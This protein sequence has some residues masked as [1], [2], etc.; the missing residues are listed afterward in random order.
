[1]I[2]FL[3]SGA[4]GLIY[5]VVWSRQLTLFVGITT[6]AHTA[7]ITAYMLGLALGSFVIG[8]LSDRHASPLRLFAWLEVAI[9]VYVACTP[10]LLSGFQNMYADLAGVVG[11]T[12]LPSHLLRFLFAVLLLLPPTFLM[13]GT[14]PVMIRGMTGALPELAQT[15]GRMYGINTLG[16]MLGTVAAG[17]LLLP[18]LGLR[19][20]LFTGVALDL[21]V[22]VIIFAMFPKPSPGLEVVGTPAGRAGELDARPSRGVF[23][24]FVFLFGLSGFAAL[25]Y[26]IAWIRA[27]TLVL[28]SSVYSFSATL[29]AFLTGIGLG[30]LI[31][32]RLPGGGNNEGRHLQA[33]V[34]TGLTGFCAMSGLW[35]IGRLPQIFLWGYQQGWNQHFA[36][37]QLFTFALCMLVMLAPTFLLGTMFPLMTTLWTR[38]CESVGRDVG[39]IY[40]A[41]TVGCIAGAM[42]GGLFLLPVLGVHGSVLLAAGVHLL[43]SFGFAWKIPELPSRNKR[44]VAGG[45]IVLY[46]CTVV[47]L[48]AWD[49]SIMTSGVFNYAS[50]MQGETTRDA[51]NKRARSFNMLYYKDG[52]DSTVNVSERD[53]ERFL[54]IN[55]KI[56]AST[57]ADLPTQFMLGQLAILAHPNPRNV[58]IVGLG[59]GITAGAIS[60]HDSVEHIDIV[61]ISP[62]VVEASAYFSEHNRRILED[63]RVNLVVADARNYLLASDRTYDVI[64]T[65]PS[66]PWI[67]G[68]A[69]LF[70]RDFFELLKAR[71][72]PGGLVSQ[73]FHIYNM[74][75]QDTR[76]VLNAYKQVF[77]RV[78][79]WLSMN[80]DLIMLGSE[81][82]HAL[83][84]ARIMDVLNK[85]ELLAEFTKIKM[86]DLGLIAKMFLFKD[87]SFA[88][89]SSG[90]PDNTDDH[91]RVE[92]RAPQH[93]YRQTKEDILREIIHN[94][95]LHPSPAPITGVARW[96]G[97]QL[98]VPSIH[99][100]LVMG[101]SVKP[102]DWTAEQQV[103]RRVY[104]QKGGA[105]DLLGEGSQAWVFWRDGDTQNQ[106]KS[107]YV[108]SE[109]SNEQL[110]AYLRE[111]K[112]NHLLAG[113]EVDLPGGKK[114]VWLLSQKREDITEVNFCITWTSPSPLGGHLQYVA[115]RDQKNPGDETKWGTALVNFAKTFRPLSD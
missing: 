76:S 64:I 90:A 10:W 52:I 6:Y 98:E 47:M 77:P 14:L 87:E 37:F 4:A 84:S 69:N 40:A 50:G 31:Y 65:Q 89:Y 22:A 70:T 100:S 29:A 11:V 80:C 107:F 67:S 114:G 26:Q 41:N 12:G 75:S 20:T 102:G 56:D 82:P 63:P 36:I 99:L 5:E 21:A 109:R 108:D 94:L 49:A 88:A 97:E 60:M 57:S 15:S 18:W 72:A 39:V 16:A 66:N 106:M 86:N 30:S 53:G 55:G 44:A 93:L 27:L 112:T 9:A 95:D 25:V 2:C 96:T 81:Q 103:W 92:F 43:T 7:V 54:V 79:A 28:G 35:M 19:Y 17:Y 78:S 38:T 58:L 42:A 115:E 73:W 32:R 23:T 3:L 111:Y 101:E 1:M 34:I 85:P 62:E 71:L 8:R 51:V 59:S 105:P 104:K 45:F 13:G 33:E 91:P 83:D 46:V 61:E 113:G 24:W 68:V 48:P 74:S 110:A